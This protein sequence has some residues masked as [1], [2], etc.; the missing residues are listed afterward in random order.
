MFS[1]SGFSERRIFREDDIE[2]LKLE[3]VSLKEY[4]CNPNFEYTKVYISKDDRI[5]PTERQE[6]FWKTEANLEGG[7]FPFLNFSKWSE[8]L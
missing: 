8:L 6:A 1:Q 5:I 3:L 2:K 7:H 4:K